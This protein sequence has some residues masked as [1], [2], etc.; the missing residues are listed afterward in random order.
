[1]NKRVWARN[2]SR[3]LS[4]EISL[5]ERAIDRYNSRIQEFDD[6]WPKGACCPTCYYGA[7]YSNL[8]VKIE[9]VR[10]WHVVLL[11]KAGRVVDAIKAYEELDPIEL[12]RSVYERK[13]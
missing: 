2:T 10:Q 3:V 5:V 6:M 1:M 11:C 12:Q 4:K 8:C 7:K 9:R 13:K